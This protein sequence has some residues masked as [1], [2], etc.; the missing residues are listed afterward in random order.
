HEGGAADHVAGHH[1]VD[2]AARGVRPLPG[3]NLIVIAL[4]GSP[5]LAFDG[6][7][8]LCSRGAEF[9]ER[10]FAFT[11]RCRPVE[12]VSF[13]WSADKTPCVDAL[14]CETL[15][16]IFLL[17][18]DVGFTGAD[19]ALLVA[20][21]A[22][23]NNFRAGELRIESPSIVQAHQPDGE[24]PAFFPDNQRGLVLAVR[25]DLILGPK[26]ARKR[27]RMAASSTGSPDST[28][29][30]LPGPSTRIICCG[31]SACT[32]SASAATASSGVR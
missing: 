23:V 6:I 32:A 7:S 3:E 17:G 20:A 16:G 29:S 14:T 18:G 13:S 19:R 11:G 15:L 9:T 31:A 26:S 10:T 4:I 2:F 27:L 1:I 24:R 25:N 28:I 5:P 30:S 8:F 21:D 22:A 12:A